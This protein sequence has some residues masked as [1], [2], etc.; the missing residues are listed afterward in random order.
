MRSEQISS[1]SLVSR[2]LLAAHQYCPE[3]EKRTEIPSLPNNAEHNIALLAYLL[4][5]GCD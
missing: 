4:R 5:R 2:T 3:L 1:F